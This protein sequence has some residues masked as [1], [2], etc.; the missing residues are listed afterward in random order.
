M[1]WPGVGPGRVGRWFVGWD[2]SGVGL[3]GGTARAQARVS[4]LAKFT[5]YYIHWLTKPKN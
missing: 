2:G 3:V 4:G 5:I 1:E